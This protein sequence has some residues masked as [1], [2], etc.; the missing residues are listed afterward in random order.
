MTHDVALPE[1]SETMLRELRFSRLQRYRTIA[2]V[3]PYV[4]QQALRKSFRSSPAARA[5]TA[6]L[7]QP[8]FGRLVHDLYCGMFLRGYRQSSGY[9]VDRATG[10]LTVLFTVFIY[11]FDDEFEVRRRRGDS[12]DGDV[13]LAA[14]GV[15]DIWG[16]IGAY[17]D[18]TGRDDEVRRSIKGV[19]LSADFDTY[20]RNTA[21]ALAKN[22]FGVTRQVVDFDSGTVLGIM[23]DLIRIF[24]GHPYHEHCALEFRNLGLAGKFLDDMADYAD[25]VRHENPNLLDA[26]AATRAEEF[27]SARSALASGTLITARWWRDNCPATFE[28]YFRWAFGHYNQ[29]HAPALRLPLDVYLMLLG[30]RRFWTISTVRASRRGS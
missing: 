10:L 13:I 12:T 24:N 2:R 11:S 7:D 3:L 20:R 15:A 5:S 14:S 25:D 23:Y 4:Y 9:P 28:E 22:N 19:L 6:E 30:T 21:K 29:V 16:T 1:M 26:L 8:E 17:L 18:A 27:A